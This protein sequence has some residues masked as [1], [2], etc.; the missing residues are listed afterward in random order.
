[1]HPIER[2]RWIAR[3]DGDSASLLAAEAAWT[4]GELAVT[5][6][7]A[8]L[9]A[10]RRL[11]DR[12]PSSGPLWWVAAR[13]VAAEDAYE[14]AAQ[15]AGLL[16]HDPTGERLAELLRANVAPREVVVV[17]PP[18]DLSPDAFTRTRPYSVR[19][20]DE[21][22]RLTSHMQNLS[23]TTEDVTGW[24]PEEA[25]GAT[26]DASVVLVEVL[27]AS[28]ELALVEPAASSVIDAAVSAGVPAWAIVGVGRALPARLAATA[29][30]RAEASGSAI[31]VSPSTFVLAVGPSGAGH[32]DAVM[33]ATTAPPGSE[34][35]HRPA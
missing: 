18:P 11:L 35:V 29:A 13:L 17:A 6:P 27:A 5:E 23:S 12:H 33:G 19:L 32:P 2:L 9:T 1:M 22:R 21:A 15:I 8:L 31:R 28:A 10:A 26:R 20:V 7:A 4:L 24:S 14:E 16:H 34:L 3:A 30:A 25:A